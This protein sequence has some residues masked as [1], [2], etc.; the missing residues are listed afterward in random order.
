MAALL[1]SFAGMS[2]GSAL[3]GAGGAVAGRLIG[4][5]AGSVIDQA[6]FG[7]NTRKHTEGRASLRSMSWRRATVLRSRAFTGARVFPAR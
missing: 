5:V 3:F 6:L 2:A 4:A 7:A 1:L